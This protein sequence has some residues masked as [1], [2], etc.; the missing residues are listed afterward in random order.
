M[1]CRTETTNS[2]RWTRLICVGTVLY[3]VSQHAFVVAYNLSIQLVISS[4]QDHY[5]NVLAFPSHC[6]L[7]RCRYS[8]TSPKHLSF[9]VHN[10]LRLD[11]TCGLCRMLWKLFANFLAETNSRFQ[12]LYNSVLRPMMHNDQSVRSICTDFDDVLSNSFD[13]T[14]QACPLLKFS[15]SLCNY[16]FDSQYWNLQCNI[17]QTS[18]HSK[19]WSPSGFVF[20]TAISA[21]V[22][23]AR[24]HSTL[25]CDRPC[26][27]NFGTPA[28]DRL[29]L[30]LPESSSR[31]RFAARPRHSP[32]PS[33]LAF[34][35]S[36]INLSRRRFSSIPVS[37]M[38]GGSV[39]RPI[40]SCNGQQR[41]ELSTITQTPRRQKQDRGRGQSKSARQA[42]C[43][44]KM[45]HC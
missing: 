15:A 32:D 35:S 42:V 20:L 38:T 43:P 36:E 8:L 7:C 10:P 29:V 21:T 5:T 13:P 17:I 24:P 40:S 18:F 22:L 28:D 33:L 31:A 27:S 39:C 34:L 44:R 25:Q 23:V 3:W 1:C 2:W 12:I 37:V 11:H 14:L 30:C 41:S 45:L 6:P 4:F 19:P 16:K 9:S 26:R